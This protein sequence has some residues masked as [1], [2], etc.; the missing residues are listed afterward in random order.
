MTALPIHF[1]PASPL[2]VRASPSCLLCAPLALL[3][4][5]FRLSTTLP[6][7]TTACYQAIHDTKHQYTKLSTMLQELEGR[8]EFLTCH[9]SYKFPD[10]DDGSLE[11]QCAEQGTESNAEQVI[12]RVHARETV[13]GEA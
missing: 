7:S 11:S 4:T 1:L 12:E 5:A 2:P 9:S 8:A 3:A 10:E 13:V 6:V